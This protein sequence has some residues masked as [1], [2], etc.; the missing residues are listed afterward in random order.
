M[1]K[2][3]FYYQTTSS[4]SEKRP[5]S[6]SNS[7]STSFQ[8]ISLTTPKQK[9][10]NPPKIAIEYSNPVLHRIIIP[11]SIP[12]Q[13]ARC[14]PKLPKKTTNNNYPRRMKKKK[15]KD[16]IAETWRRSP[17]RSKRCLARDPACAP[18]LAIRSLRMR[19]GRA[20]PGCGQKD[21]EPGRP[22]IADDGFLSRL[23]KRK[24]RTDPFL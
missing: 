17:P 11:D 7:N 8:P 9:H 4:R 6:N 22:L 19:G 21:F 24:R 16:I 2:R 13:T 20:L 23:M 18:D 5:N 3:M 1:L 10:P 12:R 14:S 15:N